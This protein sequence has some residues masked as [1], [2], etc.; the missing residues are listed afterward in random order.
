[1]ICSQPESAL[2]IVLILFD[3]SPAIVM[4]RAKFD[5]WNAAELDIEEAKV[6]VCPSDSIFLS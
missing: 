3:V 2:I 6:E 4:L 1:M 5:T